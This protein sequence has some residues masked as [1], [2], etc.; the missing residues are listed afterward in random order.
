M[1]MLQQYF[2]VF[3]CV[4]HSLGKC[5]EQLDVHRR[6]VLVRVPPAALGGPPWSRPGAPCLQARGGKA[7]PT[8]RSSRT[9][10]SRP[11]SAG[12]T[13]SATPTTSTS[14]GPRGPASWRAAGWGWASTRPW[15]RA[16]GRSR[17]WPTHTGAAAHP[18]SHSPAHSQ[19][20]EKLSNTFAHSLAHSCAHF[21]I[22]RALLHTLAVLHSHTLLHTLSHSHSFVHTHSLAY[23]LAHFSALTCTLW[24]TFAHTH[25]LSHSHTLLHSLAHFRAHSQSLAQSLDHFHA[26][27]LAH[28]RAHSFTLSHSL[29]CWCSSLAGSSYN[30]M[31]CCTRA[32]PE[33]LLVKNK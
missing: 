33:A 5:T 20:L 2:P 26:H 16:A 3:M 28:F 6:E 1:Y 29:G 9:T 15:W 13:W 4:V 12:S 11:G 8:R 17:E 10:R 24:H 30:S 19:S 22:S 23:T 31:F 32:A 7:C 21:V 14:P 27:F 25:S 18:L